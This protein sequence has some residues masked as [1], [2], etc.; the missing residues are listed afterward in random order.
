MPKY[1]G[2]D[3]LDNLEKVMKQN[4]VSYQSDFEI[5]RKILT[6]IAENASTLPLRERT[7]LWMSRAHGT[8]CLKEWDVF[9]EPT[10]AHHIWEYYSGATSQRTLAYAIE[11]TGMEGKT[12]TGNLYPLDYWEHVKRVKAQS[13]PADRLRLVYEK[14]E[15]FQDSGKSVWKEEDE[16][17]GRFQYLEYVPN[18][19]GALEAVLCQEKNERSRMRNGKI[20]NHIPKLAS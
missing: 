1:V 16:I 20:E 10:P 18:D 7:Y 11:V 3:L 14:G 17:L 12:V 8:W 15:R 5:D 6:E 19:R 4:T 13:L 2:I 9:L